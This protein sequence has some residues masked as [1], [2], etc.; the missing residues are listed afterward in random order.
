MLWRIDIRS[1]VHPT[2]KRIDFARI[3]RKNRNFLNYCISLLNN[4]LALNYFFWNP[5]F[6]RVSQIKAQESI[7][8][9]YLFSYSYKFIILISL[10]KVSN[11]YSFRANQN[12]SDSFRYL[13]P[14]ESF[15]TN[16]KNFLYLVW[17][18]TVKNQSGL[19]RFNPQQQLEPIRIRSIRARINPKRIVNKDQSES[20]RPRIHSDW[21]WL[22]TWFRIGSNCC[23][24]LN[25]IK[26]QFADIST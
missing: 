20:F 22:E 26:H 18:K 16:P 12:Y 24:G 21:F 2:N 15:Q 25:R 13:Y 10:A 8:K 5:C 14:R 19:I 1:K 3:D 7:R 23:C 11:R 6:S 9:K 17:W 4:F